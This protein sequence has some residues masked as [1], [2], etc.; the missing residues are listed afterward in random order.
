MTLAEAGEIFA[1]WERDPPTHLIVQTIAR[2]LGWTPQPM[3]SRP[4]RIEEIAASAPPG[5]AVAH[6]GAIDMPVPVLN[7]EA[8][9]SRNRARAAEI[10]RRASHGGAQPLPRAFGAA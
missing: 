6:G 5:L 7:P 1:Y 9:R 4:P 8:L 3:S 10:A 2:L